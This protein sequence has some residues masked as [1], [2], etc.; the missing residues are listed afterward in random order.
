MNKTEMVTRINKFNKEN[1][2]VTLKL[3]HK[4][5]K[6]YF[7]IEAEIDNAIQKELF[8]LL[9]DSILKIVSCN[10]LVEFNVVG[11]QDDTIE[12]IRADDV[13]GYS[14]LIADM[15]E[16]N[17]LAENIIELGEINFYL[18]EINRGNDNIKIFRRYSKAKSLSKGLLFKSISSKLSK[19]DG[20]IFQVDNIIDFIVFN[21]TEIIIFNR[22][23]FE[24][25]TNYRDNYIENLNRALEEI[26]NSELI[27]NMEKFEEDCKSSIRIA[28]QFTK[29]MQ[30]NSINLIL[31]N[32]EAIKEAIKEADLPIDFTNNKFQYESREQLSI[33]VALLSDKYA[34]TLIGK[35]ITTE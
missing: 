16:R 35:R 23:S 21:D 2:S 20:N 12:L 25:I 3:G 30:E 31:N 15:K 1:S 28:K 5:N 32:P 29:A 22:Y 4:N 11:H 8:E 17:N 24:V 6:N 27:N 34:K 14:V 10:D 7:F 26:D 9:Q 18:L 33:L 13:D 19:I